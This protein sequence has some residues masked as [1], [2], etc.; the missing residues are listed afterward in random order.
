[1]AAQPVGRDA[2]SVGFSGRLS[3]LLRRFLDSEQ[4]DEP[5]EH[6]S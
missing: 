2:A 4:I 5:F 6:F 1:M 3:L